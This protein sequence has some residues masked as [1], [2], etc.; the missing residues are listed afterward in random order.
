[1]EILEPRGARF[2]VAL[3]LLRDGQ[4][5]V[6]DKVNFSLA[7]NGQLVVG[8]PSSFWPP[9]NITEATALRDLQRAKA[10]AEYLVN[11]SARFADVFEQHPPFF[12]LFAY[13]GRG[14]ENEWARLVN[15]KV[16]WAKGAA[17]G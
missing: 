5:F 13:E 6:F 16:L 4:S 2:E 3:D 8:I 9:Q 1:M 7:A 14:G 17:H 10:V 11:Q 15:G 12:M